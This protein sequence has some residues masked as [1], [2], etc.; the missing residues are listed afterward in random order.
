MKSKNSYPLIFVH[1][2]FG[3]GTAIGIDKYSP[4]WG[5]TTGNLMEYLTSAGYDC[6]AASVGPVSSAWDC[7]CEL[8]AQLTGTRVDYGVA[9]SE[10]FHHDRYGRKYDT[11]IIDCFGERK[12]H[13]I[14]HSHGGQV[15]RLLAHLLT[16]GDEAEKSRTAEGDISPLF[17]GGKED[18]ISSVTTLCSPNNGTTL[19]E[20]AEKANIVAPV[21]RGM[22]FVLALIGRTFLHERLV[23]FQL[24]QYSLTPL[25]GEKKADKILTAMNRMRDNDDNVLTDLSLRGAAALNDIIEIS[26]N[27]NYFC[28]TSNGMSAGR[29]IPVNIK[30]PFLKPLSKIIAENE[31]PENQFGIEFDDSWKENDGL[32]NTPSGRNPIDEPAREFDGRIESGIWNIMPVLIGDHGQAGGLLNEPDKLHAFY[33]SLADMLISTEETLITK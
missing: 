4:Y 22:D 2:M 1:G 16:Y 27:I 18:L 9:H 19:F 5:A 25:R 31:L 6:R 11:P 20:I 24:E 8:Y 26:K 29:Q 14:G 12:I 23:D 30:N 3:W 13:L 33:E 32:V 7:A 28:Y 10:K 17:T 21:G 15:I